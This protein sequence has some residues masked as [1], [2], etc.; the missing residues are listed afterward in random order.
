MYQ[1]FCDI[2]NYIGHFWPK[3]A[4]FRGGTLF[5]A[6]CPKEYGPLGPPWGPPQGP[7]KGP[8]RPGPQ[9]RGPKK[10]GPK[11]TPLFTPFGG[12]GAQRSPRGPKKPPWE[13]SKKDPFFGPQ[14]GTLFGSQF[15]TLFYVKYL[16]ASIGEPTTPTRQHSWVLSCG[17]VGLGGG[18]AF[19]V[20]SPKVLTSVED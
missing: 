15:G 17:V 20:V 13:G 19:R 16:N 1:R 9:K 8:P 5:R 11:R 18:R 4:L 10:G 3:M 7:K 12:V 14:K 6:K 2:S